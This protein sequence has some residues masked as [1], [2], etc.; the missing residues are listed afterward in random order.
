MSVSL[1]NV[2]LWSFC[3]TRQINYHFSS[4]WKLWFLHLKKHQ[5]SFTAV[6]FPGIV[7]WQRRAKLKKSKDTAH[8]LT[9]I[10]GQCCPTEL[11][12]QPKVLYIPPTI[13]VFS[14]TLTLH[15]YACYK[16]SANGP[17]QQQAGCSKDP[18]RHLHNWATLA[19][20]WPHRRAS[21]TGLK[22]QIQPGCWPPHPEALNISEPW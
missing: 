6:C 8:L 4:A 22:E 15:L 12:L 13:G 7:W 16:R 14:I 10:P 11:T 9:G 3:S 17:Q 21:K 18:P 1:S 5:S 19:G 2:V 20:V